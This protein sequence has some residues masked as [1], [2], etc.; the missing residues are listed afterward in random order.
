MHPTSFCL[1]S[2]SARNWFTTE[3][4]NRKGTVLYTDVKSL[5]IN[6]ETGALGKPAYLTPMFGTRGSEVQILSPRP[7]LSNNLHPSRGAENR[8]LVT[9]Q[10][11]IFAARSFDQ[12][13]ETLE[14]ALGSGTYEKVYFV[15]RWSQLPVCS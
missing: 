13:F 3:G 15:T 7:F 12:C 8:P 5:T 11:V 4:M 9:H 14:I 1:R 2:L 6:A 10:G